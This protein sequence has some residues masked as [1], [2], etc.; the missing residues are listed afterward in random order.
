MDKISQ[1][2][3]ELLVKVLLFLPT[4]VAVSTS[5]LSKRWEFLWMWLPKLE[6]DYSDYS[7]S[8]RQRLRSSIN[9]NMPL[10]KAPVIES[11]RLKLGGE[12]QLNLKI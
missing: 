7:E 3:D 4:K 12:D 9:L 11:L 1:L 8:E 6:Y 10:H 2:P 5:V